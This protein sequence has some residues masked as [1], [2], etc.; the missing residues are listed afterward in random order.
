ME[1]G[2]SSYDSLWEIHP[3]SMVDCS[4][5]AG[6][7]TVIVHKMRVIVGCE[8][9]GVVRDAFKARG[10]DVWSCDLVPSRIPGNH[11]I[12]NVLDC[13]DEGWDLGI[14]HPPCTYLTNAGVRHLHSVPS[15]NGVVTKV[16]GIARWI[17]LDR[18]AALFKIILR[19]PILKIAV[20]NPIP[21]KYAVARIGRKYDQMIQP[22]EFDHGETKATCL[23]LKGLPTLMATVIHTG[24]ESRIHNMAPGPNRARDRSVTFSGIAKAMANQW[25]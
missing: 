24:R 9:S 2:G 11:I 7:S 16:H 21:H 20:E 14:F 8:E 13:L 1:E 18:A 15:R 3:V 5:V 6:N 22:W 25:G 12:G 23:W 19:A 10:H 4:G 17:E